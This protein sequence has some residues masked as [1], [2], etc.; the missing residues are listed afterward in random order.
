M[1]FLMNDKLIRLDS[2]D[3][4]APLRAAQI[5]ALSFSFVTRLGR[6][7]FAEEP[8]LPTSAPDRARR[9]AALIIA[10][11]PQINA[12]LFVAPSTGCDPDEV[13]TR[14]VSL[15]LEVLALLNEREEAGALTNVYADRQVWRRLAA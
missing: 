13:Q 14:F 8:L 10:R 6:D 5:Q 2:H 7:L 11:Q 9:L 15:G 12:A 4:M 1:L 3:L